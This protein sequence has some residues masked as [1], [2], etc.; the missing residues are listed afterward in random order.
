MILPSFDPAAV[1]NAIASEKVNMAVLVPTMIDFV[2][3]YLQANPADM[4]SLRK[5][6]YGASPISEA[7]LRRATKSLPNARFYQGYGPSRVGGRHGRARTRLPRIR[8]TQRA[9]AAGRRPTPGT[10]IRIVDEQMNEVPR[11]QTGEVVARGPSVILGYW[12]KPEQTEAAIINGWL[13]TG[14]AG[15]M[16][17]EGFIFLVD[18]V[19][20]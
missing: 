12:R 20:T 2:D 1:V 5:L 15:Y 13:R 8:R 10:D 16:D 18:R 4:S 3:R 14:D 7:L 19:R 17:E 6:V 11:G 9:P